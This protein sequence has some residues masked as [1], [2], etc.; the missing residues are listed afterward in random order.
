MQVISE[1]L[2]AGNQTSTSTTFDYMIKS[3]SSDWALAITPASTSNY[4]LIMLAAG[5]AFSSSGTQNRYLV[6]PFAN[7]AG[8]G[9]T[10]LFSNSFVGTY[11]GGAS[12]QY[13]NLYTNILKYSPA[14][15]SV[16]TIKIGYKVFYSGYG[17]T[18]RMNPQSGAETSLTVMEIDGT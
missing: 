7:I 5:I 2:G 9:F 16:V 4:L 10:Q 8:G 12:P 6:S 13:E 18:I 14:T 1:Q 3:D 17:A 11:Q 15:T